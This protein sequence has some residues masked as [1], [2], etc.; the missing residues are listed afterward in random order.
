[1][2][3]IVIPNDLPLGYDGDK[4]IDEIVKLNR[5][6]ALV[7]G[8]LAEKIGRLERMRQEKFFNDCENKIENGL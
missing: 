6:H 7:S 2:S 4:L 3:D 8:M 1:M 5:L